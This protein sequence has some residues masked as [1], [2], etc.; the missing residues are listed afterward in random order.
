[1][2]NS[3]LSFIPKSKSTTMTLLLFFLIF[4]AYTSTT[5]FAATYISDLPCLADATTFHINPVLGIARDLGLNVTVGLARG[6]YTSG[7]RAIPV[8]VT[9]TGPFNEFIIFAQRIDMAKIGSFGNLTAGIGY[10]TNANCNNTTP[11]S[12]IWSTTDTTSLGPRLTGLTWTPPGTPG[13]GPLQFFAC[14]AVVGNFGNTTAASTDASFD[15]WVSEPYAEANA[16]SLVPPTNVP[17]SM[18]EMTITVV[19]GFGSASPTDIEVIGGAGRSAG[20]AVG[21]AV[22]MIGFLWALA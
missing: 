9:A 2:N 5:T 16:I 21:V 11:Q 10:N 15:C 20:W 3:L 14:I 13:S 19:K 8:T 6:Q 1:M 18:N 12:T 17:V 22:G 7:G 4:L